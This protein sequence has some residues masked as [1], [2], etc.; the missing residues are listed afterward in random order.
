V[1]RY[2]FDT[3]EL[4]R[5]TADEIGTKCRTESQA[6]AIAKQMARCHV[7]RSIRSGGLPLDAFIVIRRAC[8]RRLSFVPYS[9]AFEA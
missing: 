1:R 9:A 4:D 5:R 6:V 3:V 8:G 7:R 2:Y